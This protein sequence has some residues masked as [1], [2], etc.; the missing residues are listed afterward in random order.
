M[1]KHLAAIATCIA[2]SALAQPLTAAFTFQGELN[3][4]RLLPFGLDNRWVPA[5][6]TLFRKQQ[7]DWAAYYR[8]VG[9]LADR[10]KASREERLEQLLL[11]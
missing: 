6:A 11:P 7:G 8:A 5:F 1:L 10:D 9:E 2:G 4:A 3:N